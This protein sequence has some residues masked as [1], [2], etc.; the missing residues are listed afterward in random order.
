MLYIIKLM[1]DNIKFDLTSQQQEKRKENS[2][3]T[4]THKDKQCVFVCVHT[5]LPS[6]TIQMQRDRSD[7]MCIRWNKCKHIHNTHVR[8]Y[9]PVA[10]ESHKS[11]WVF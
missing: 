3:Y 5:Q 9:K 11:T 10:V 8:T 6:L 1:L 2:T 4:N 7:L